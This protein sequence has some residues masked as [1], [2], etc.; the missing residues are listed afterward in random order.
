MDLYVQGVLPDIVTAE[1]GGCTA[2]REH[3]IADMQCCSPV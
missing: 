3:V 1:E 2:D